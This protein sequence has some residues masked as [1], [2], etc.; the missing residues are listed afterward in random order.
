MQKHKILIIDKDPQ[1]IKVLEK[2]LT[3]SGFECILTSNEED[4]IEIAAK[5]PPDLII[6][7]LQDSDRDGLF[8]NPEI[9][10]RHHI[11]Q[12]PVLM[13]TTMCSEK[14]KI[15]ALESGIDDFFCKP[16]SSDELLA[17]IKAIVRQNTRTRDSNPTTN[18]PGGNALEEEIGRRL[19]R[20]SIFVLMHVDIDNFKAYADSY[21]F[22]SANKMIRLC[23]NIL[24]QAAESMNDKDIFIAHIGGDD[25]IIVANP[26]KYESLAKK[27]LE[28]FD[29]AVPSCFRKEDI[30]NGFFK[31]RDRKNLTKKF[32]ITTISIGIVSNQEVEYKDAT[33]IG[34]VLVQAKNTA[35]SMDGKILGKSTYFFMK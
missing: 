7:D 26:D 31:S 27:V 5:D 11:A 24:V 3:K 12:I 23:G 6:L 15:F 32:P 34:R 35:K 9:K 22:N 30:Q 16:F 33:E 13:L 17:K 25:F 14:D 19:A 2:I 8:M 18:L 29:S 21:G 20:K 4:A 1:I 28:L 10:R